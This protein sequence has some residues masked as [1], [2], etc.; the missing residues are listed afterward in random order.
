[1]ITNVKKE[2]LLH[3]EQLA[4]QKVEIAEYNRT[5]TEFAIRIRHLKQEIQDQDISILTEHLNLKHTNERLENLTQQCKRLAQQIKDKK[6][7]IAENKEKI[8]TIS[9]LIEVAED[10]LHEQKK[11]YDNIQAEQKILNQQLTAHNGTLHKLYDEIHI[12]Q[13]VLTKGE[14]AYQERMKQI[15]QTRK[16]RDEVEQTLDGIRNEIE[17]FDELKVQIGHVQRDIIQEKLRTK[18]LLEEM[19]KSVNIHRWRLLK[20]TDTEAYDKIK[21][22]HLLQRQIMRKSAKA[23]VKDSMIREREKLYEELRRVLAR[24][25]GR[26]EQEKLQMFASTVK[27]KKGELRAMRDELKMYQAR[28]YECKYD[29]EKINKDMELLKQEFFHLK[30]KGRRAAAAESM[31]KSAEAQLHNSDVVSQQP[32]LEEFYRENPQLLHSSKPPKE[33]KSRLDH[34]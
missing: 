10:E 28:V 27:Q 25:P 3:T 34:A 4:T 23:E 33:L 32:G 15:V 19:K 26:E 7:I 9:K 14:V 13:S 11:L 12:Q 1:M 24:Q 22:V 6:V 18:A 20:D 30:M 21:Q 2:R 17:R 31:R 29:I 8:E 5:L 16:E